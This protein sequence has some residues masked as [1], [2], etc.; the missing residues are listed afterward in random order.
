MSDKN[1]HRNNTTFITMQQ[2]PHTEMNMAWRLK[3]LQGCVSSEEGLL[4]AI[5]FP[6][7]R[8][9]Y[10]FAWS[11][12]VIKQLIL[13]HNHLATELRLVP[14]HSITKEHQLPTGTPLNQSYILHLN[15][16]GLIRALQYLS[17]VAN[18]SIT[19]TQILI[20]LEKSHYLPSLSHPD[21]GRTH[22]I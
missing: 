9:S 16:L 5:Y 15:C 2:Q 22:V 10:S 18:S 19:S 13:T 20:L 11:Q 12:T 3:C 17:I 6:Q 21:A 4:N 14:D 1:A 8:Q 7:H